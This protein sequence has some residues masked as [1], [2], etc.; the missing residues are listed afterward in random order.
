MQHVPAIHIEA[1]DFVG[2]F[3]RMVEDIVLSSKRRVVF[4]RTYRELSKLTN[5]ELADIGLS[6]GEI[7]DVARQG[8]EAI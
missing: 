4:N 5:R 7:A 1:V 6:R 2:R 8:A 3:N